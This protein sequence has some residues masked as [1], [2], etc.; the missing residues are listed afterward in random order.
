MGL[1]RTWRFFLIAALLLAQQSSVVHQIWH[2]S[3]GAASLAL[4]PSGDAGKGNPLCD[5]HAALKAV[6]AAINGAA[7]PVVLAEVVAVHP[8][9]PTLPSPSLPGLAPS[10]RDPPAFL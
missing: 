8:L 1:S 5:Q 9:A 4:Q 3:A 2:G 7:C 6:L 10:S